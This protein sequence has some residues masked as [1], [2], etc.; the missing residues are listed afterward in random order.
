[1]HFLT[2]SFRCYDFDSVEFLMRLLSRFFLLPVVVSAFVPTQVRAFGLPSGVPGLG[3]GGG[4]TNVLTEQAKVR[5]VNAIFS[6]VGENAFEGG[7]LV[8]AKQKWAC[9]KITQAQTILQAINQPDLSSKA[10]DLREKLF[11]DWTQ[12]IPDE[13]L[14]PTEEEVDQ[15]T[16]L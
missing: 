7:K 5:S 4:G 12:P 1:M 14:A 16:I 10:A 8:V 2:L 9:E 6:E 3:G 13:M 11:C 15:Q